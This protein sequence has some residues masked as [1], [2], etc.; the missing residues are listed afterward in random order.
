MHAPPGIAVSTLWLRGAAVGLLVVGVDAIIELFTPDLAPTWPRFG[1]ENALWPW[2]SRVTT[3]FNVLLPIAGTIVV[4]SWLDRLTSGWTRHRV[5]CVL[6]L[7]L[8]EGAIAA[9]RADQWLDIVVTGLIGG[10]VSTILFALVLRFDLR[11]VPALIAVYAATGAVVDA[12]EKASV[13]AWLLAAI[14]VFMAVAISWAVTRYLVARGP[15]AAEAAPS[16]VPEPG[17]ATG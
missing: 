11:A 10:L 16:A 17:A 15:V 13:Q 14:A 8:G 1:A 5:L 6:I 4:L 9:M 3:S 12:I 7:I 2:L